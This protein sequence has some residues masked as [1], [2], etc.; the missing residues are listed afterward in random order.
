[1]F[2]EGEAGDRFAVRN[3][4]ATAVIEGLGEY[5][6]EYMTNGA[7]L[8]LGG[9]GNGLANG[10]SG[11]FLYQYDPACTIDARISSDSVVVGA[12]TGVDDPSPRC[13]T[14]RRG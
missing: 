9:Y 13:T 6:C 14:P 12:I 3:S 4:G 2:V 5:G 1:M 7:V 8:N 10:M 11:G